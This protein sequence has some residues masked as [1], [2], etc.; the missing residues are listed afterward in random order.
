MIRSLLLKLQSSNWLYSI[1]K[2]SKWY[3]LAS[4]STKALG[5]ILLPIYT[6]Y[7]TPTDYGILTSLEVIN[8]LLPFFFSFSLVAA[9]DRFYHQKG[10]QQLHLPTLF[11]SIFWFVSLL[12]GILVTLVILSSFFWMPHFLGVPAYPYA[13]LGFTP[14]LFTEIS[15]LGFAFFRQSLQA[16]KVSLI[17]IGSAII[18][19]ALSLFFVIYLEMGVMGRLWGNVGAALFSFTAILIY[20]Y[21]K[22]LIHF[23]VDQKLLKECLIYSVPLIPLAASNWVNIFS[24]RLI[25]G[26]Y[27]NIE[28]VGIYSIAFHISMILYFLGESI[29]QVLA[30]MTMAGLEKNKNHTKQRLSDYTFYLWILLLFGCLFMFLFSEILITYFLDTSF[31]ATHTVIPILSVA[32]TFQ[33]LH[34]LYGQ[35]IKFHKKTKIFTIGAVGSSFLN[36]VLNLLLIPEYGYIAAAYTTLVVSIIYALFIIWQSDKVEKLSIPYF[37]YLVSILVFLFLI[38]ITNIGNITFIGRILI[39]SG[40]SSFLLYFSIIQFSRTK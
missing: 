33:L 30:P 40:V 27:D 1:F 16:K 18:N 9:F 24:D 3:L 11:S 22:Q 21:R 12:G 8:N 17:L 25:I 2:H 10:D 32:I 19:I 5:F 4:L 39:F 28:A 6:R 7:L 35:V 14:I 31:L 37:K 20:A 29:I 26:K 36:I 38:S 23:V 15:L 13:I 34:R